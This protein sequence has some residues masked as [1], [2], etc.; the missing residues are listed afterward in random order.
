MV[1]FPSPRNAELT[2]Q[3]NL[4][5]LL[6]VFSGNCLLNAYI[7]LRI[8]GGCFGICF[9]NLCTSVSEDSCIHGAT[10]VGQGKLS[11]LVPISEP[12]HGALAVMNFEVTP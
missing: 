4:I 12:L 8:N 5:F 3:T 9:M 7:F 6:S 1:W 11:D 2:W 10:H